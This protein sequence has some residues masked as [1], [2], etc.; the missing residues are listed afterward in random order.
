MLDP[1]DLADQ[2][3]AQTR[4]TLEYGRHRFLWTWL[5]VA[6]LA[7]LTSV[8]LILAANTAKH[9][10][11][12]VKLTA[13]TAKTQA[14]ATAASNEEITKYLKGEQGIPGV[15]GANGKDGAPGQPGSVPSELPPGPT[16]PKG[17]TGAA[18]P[19][20]EPGAAGT[21]GET[22]TAGAA[23]LA[24]AAGAS[25]EIGAKGATGAKGETGGRGDPGPPGPAGAVGPTGPAGP[26]APPLATQTIT[27]VSAF[28]ALLD[29]QVTANCPAGTTLTGGGFRWVPTSPL[30]VVVASFPQGNG[31]FVEA[32]G[33][34]LPAGTAWDLTAFAVCTT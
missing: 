14:D 2:I 22:G 29:K 30:I 28:D 32:R 25:G 18:G 11:E 3:D 24:G 27:A 33:D 26:A 1:E 10:N 8:S 5:A 12:N 7:I 13:D 23:G 6:L 19:P 17:A 9:Q 34:A 21:P 31:W 16:G 20:G 15:P 4:R